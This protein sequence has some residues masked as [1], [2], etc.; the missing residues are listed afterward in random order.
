MESPLLRA[1]LIR[2]TVWDDVTATTLPRHT[3][4]RHTS[5]AGAVALGFYFESMRACRDDW[6]S[7]WGNIRTWAG[8]VE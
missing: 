2:L 4:T 5:Q 6:D 3:V 8:H 1:P 7:A